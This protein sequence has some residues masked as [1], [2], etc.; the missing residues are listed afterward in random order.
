MASDFVIDALTRL[1]YGC[2][3]V[4]DRQV[5]RV[6]LIGLKGLW[7]VEVRDEDHVVGGFETGL[8]HELMIRPIG[9]TVYFMPPYVLA[10]AELELLAWRTRATLEY[11][12]NTYE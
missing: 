9:R 7:I 11:V 5:L 2:N 3:E 8:R 6:N 1:A 10:D 4:L 12:L